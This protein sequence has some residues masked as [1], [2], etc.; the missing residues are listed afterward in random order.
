MSSVERSLG[1]RCKS[2]SAFGLPEAEFMDK[3]L[4]ECLFALSAHKLLFELL[5]SLADEWAA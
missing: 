3:I 4:K 2:L 1:P 5:Y